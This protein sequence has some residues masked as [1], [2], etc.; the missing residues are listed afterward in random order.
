MLFLTTLTFALRGWIKWRKYGWDDAAIALAQVFAWAQF[1]V[2]AGGLCMG[3]GKQWS[4]L[5]GQHQEHV[6]VVW[7]HSSLF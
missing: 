5:D 1:G 3:M 4:L 2:V 7:A 6:A